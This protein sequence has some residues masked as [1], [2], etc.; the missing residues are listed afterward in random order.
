V[1]YGLL[2]DVT[3]YAQ[4]SDGMEAHY[5]AV[6]GYSIFSIRANYTT[7]L[8]RNVRDVHASGD[9]VYNDSSML[10]IAYFR[11]QGWL[12]HNSAG[13][14]LTDPEYAGNTLCDV[15]NAG[16]QQ[17]IASWLAYEIRLR[18][19]PAVFL[20]NGQCSNASSWCY[21]FT[22]TPPINP[23][24]G[25]AWTD[26]DVQNA[27]IALYSTIKQAV[28]SNI[29]VVANSIGLGTGYKYF[30]FGYRTS[31]LQMLGHLDGFMSEQ[32]M[33]DGTVAYLSET[34]TNSNYDWKDCVDEVVDLESQFSGKNIF[35]VSNAIE[36][37]AA[38]LQTTAQRQQYCTYVYASML[39]GIGTKNTY[40]L[41]LGAW[42]LQNM[43]SLFSINIGTPTGPYYQD[44]NGD[45]VRQ[46]TDGVVSVNPS[47]STRGPLAADSASIAVSSNSGLQG[48]WYINNQLITNA[49]KIIYSANPTVNFQFTQTG[50]NSTQLICA[51]Y[52][53]TTLRLTLNHI[54]T[55][56]WTG[57]Y[58]FPVGSHAL[59]LS[60]T[61]GYTTLAMSADSSVT[62]GSSLSLPLITLAVG[63]FVGVAVVC[64]ASFLF[65]LFINRRF[66]ERAK[67][68]HQ[69]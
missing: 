66:I 44:S 45:Y 25:A 18:N 6:P 29:I 26:T 60:A 46:F 5:D 40:W 48:N 27:Y 67:R 57:T 56:T 38:G 36:S 12:L 31:A 4:L 68:R 65:L 51:V 69:Q 39:L 21:G 11:S 61:D 23:R 49:S 47:T 19:Y 50:G 42:G 22:H 30:N 13:L 53:G 62:V 59:S 16:Y 58:M 2:S 43:Q 35:L 32:W 8:Y 63:F 15:G 54:G 37:N 3:Q 10:E 41:Y 52:E 14:E 20:D 1:Y 28:G 24:T 17:Y 7:F 64:G 55:G 34:H 9:Y 33:G